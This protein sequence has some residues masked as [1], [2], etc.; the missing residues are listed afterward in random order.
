[1]SWINISCNKLEAALAAALRAQ[2]PRAQLSLA[3]LGLQALVWQLL[4]VLC[5]AWRAR[6]TPSG[7]IL[8][9]SSHPKTCFTLPK[10]PRGRKPAWSSAWSSVRVKGF[11]Q[12]R[13][14]LLASLPAALPTHA[15]G[16][17]GT[18]PGAEGN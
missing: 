3:L 15:A 6:N 14:A 17:A 1:M 10:A 18:S 9:L 7:P 8:K 5:C 4:W 13:E 2:L 16:R 11:Q 12:Q